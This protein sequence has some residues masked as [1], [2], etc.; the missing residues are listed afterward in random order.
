[1]HHDYQQK[2]D[3]ISQALPSRFT[4]NLRKVRAE[5]PSL[6]TST[7][8]L[9][10]SHDDLC[11]MNIFVDPYTGHITGIIDWADARILPFGISLWGFENMLGWMDSQGWHYYNNHHKL[12][13]LFWH[14]F[15]RTVDGVSET[16]KQ[17]IRVA[18][19][20]GF[21]LRYGFVWEDGVR[22]IPAKEPDSAFRYLD[23]FYTTGNRCITDPAGRNSGSLFFKD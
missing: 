9:V 11:E 16:D 8:P 10:L 13:D 19:M 1:M 2:F 22:E 4:E 23:A 15:E 20:P 6:F 14:T 17:A 7:Y 3:L 12:E 21:F 5:L 18:R